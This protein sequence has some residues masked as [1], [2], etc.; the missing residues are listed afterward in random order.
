MDK[1]ARR[2]PTPDPAPAA[3]A[4]TDAGAA[5]S[6][7]I[8]SPQAIERRSRRWLWIGLGLLAVLAVGAVGVMVAWPRLKPRPRNLDAVERVAGNYLDALVRDDHEAA[9][10]LSTIDEPPGIRSVRNLTHE[11]TRD[12]GLRGSF[13]PIGALHGRI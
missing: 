11:R 4:T 2:P 3:P 13:A 12:Q 7:F 5:G 6:V 1:N 8:S 9:R 10:Q